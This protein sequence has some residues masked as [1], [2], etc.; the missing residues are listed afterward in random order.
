MKIKTSRNISEVVLAA[1]AVAR[2]EIEQYGLPSLFHYELS[3]EKAEMLAKKANANV[4]LVKIGLALMDVKIGQAFAEKRLAEHVA[5]SSDFAKTF[6][7]PY[8]LSEQEVTVI[9][10]CIE[11][12]HGKIPFS[13][14]EAEVCA[15]ADC[16]R[17]M[18]PKGVLYYLT[19]LAK[20]GGDFSA[21]I[22]QMEAKYDEKAALLSLSAA[23]KEL[24]PYKKAIKELI[25]AT[26]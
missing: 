2:K 25:N 22:N 5:M 11:A 12:H 14:I 21:Q 15:N 6:L 13:Y 9:I 4:E 17:F 18:H 8:N 24:E 26:R 20:R 10:N 16:Y 3:M 19:T 1:D 23:K 7:A